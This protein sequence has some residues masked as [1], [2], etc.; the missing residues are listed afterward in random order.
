MTQLPV[1]DTDRTFS[2][3][4][5]KIS[6][7]K[8]LMFTCARGERP[9]RLALFVC[10]LIDRGNAWA[11]SKRAQFPFCYIAHLAAAVKDYSR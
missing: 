8:D 4:E 9:D 11:F 1:R 5:V 2:E 7:R 10:S 3:R 6:C